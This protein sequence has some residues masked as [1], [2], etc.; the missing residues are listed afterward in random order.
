MGILSMMIVLAMTLAPRQ[1]QVQKGGDNPI[2]KITINVVERE[3]T[4]INYQHRSGSTTIDFKGTPLLPEARGEAKVESKQGRIDVNAEFDDLQ[5]ATR[6]GPEYLTYVLWAISPEGRAVNLGEVLL[7][8]TKSKLDVSSDLQSFGMVVTAE[9]YF[10]V[11]QPSDVVVMQNFLRP[12]TRGQVQPIQ[13]KYELLQRGQYSVNVPPGELKPIPL[14][15]KTPLEIFEARNAVRIARW[16]GADKDAAD[17]FAKAEQSLNQA[18]NYLGR[19]QTKP[20]IMTAR[21]AVQTAEDARLIALKRQEEARLERERTAA[22]ERE[23]AAKAEADRSARA[24]AEAENQQRLAEDQR[25]RAEEQQRVAQ[26]QQRLEAQ[27]RAQAEADTAAAKAAADRARAEAEL[28]QQQ[29]ANDRQAAQAE[30][31]RARQAADQA[32]RE[33]QQLRIQL[34]EQ[35]NKILEKRDTARGLIVN[36]SDVL[37]DTAKYTLKPGAREKLAKISGIVLAH[38]GLTLSVEGHTDSVGSEEYN[39][40]LSEQRA[41]SVRDYLVSQSVP[42]NS[43]TA[44]GFGKSQPVASNDTAVGRQQNRRV[45]MVVSGDIIGTP[46]SPRSSLKNDN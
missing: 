2:Y 19:K 29:A 27:R 26:E 40:K 18:E 39:Q 16:V 42:S 37:F 23:A 10:S 9:P 17:S 31:D 24:R 36:M 30:L 28:A 3:A 35:F 21:Q 8:G 44:R 22:A 13:A 25:R 7:N 12:E 33:K 6:F 32:E 1:V 4:A 46:L 38:P 43:I 34:V 45:E 14:D 5:P 20:S 15:P 41:N 11:T